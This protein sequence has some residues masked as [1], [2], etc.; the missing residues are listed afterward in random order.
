MSSWNNVVDS[1]FF[2]G[3]MA[4]AFLIALVA[5]FIV[6]IVR[7]VVLWMAMV[8]S[9]LIVAAQIMG[10]KNLMGE[11]GGKI[12]NSLIVPIKVAGVFTGI[13]I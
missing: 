8:F 1:V 9:P 5:F 10:M 3:I 4:L 12:L 7:V 13:F 6:L 2:S 11:I